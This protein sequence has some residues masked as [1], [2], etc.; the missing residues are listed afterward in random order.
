MK[1]KLELEF[2]FVEFIPS[3]LKNGI[4]YISIEYATAVHLCCCGC[5]KEVI[6][7]LSPTDWSLLFDGNSISLYPSIGNWGFKCKSHYWIKHNNV[8]WAP[9]WS[10]KEIQY[11]RE[12]DKKQKEKY[13]DELTKSKLDSSP[14]KKPNC[15]LWNRIIKLF[16]K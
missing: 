13:F 3:K 10:T 15:S 6:T 12:Y 4:V 16:S 11:T 14:Y 5:G 9:T 7:P 8:K 1:S 2:K